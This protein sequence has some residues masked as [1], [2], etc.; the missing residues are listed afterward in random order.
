MQAWR[1]VIDHPV[2]SD[3]KYK[4]ILYIYDI[5]IYINWQVVADCHWVKMVTQRM[6]WGKKE[7]SF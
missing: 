2:T 1:P 5:Y 3:L 6:L 7:A 4:Y